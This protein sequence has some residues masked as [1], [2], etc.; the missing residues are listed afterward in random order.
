MSIDISYYIYS[1]PFMVLLYL[2]FTFLSIRIWCLWKDIDLSK[3]DIKLFFNDSFFTRN[4]IYVYCFIIFFLMHGFF[5]GTVV[6]DMYFKT[7]EVLTLSGLVLFT[8]DWYSV[9]GKCSTRRSQPQELID[10]SLF[11]KD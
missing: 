8:Y 1:K 11:K 3:P 10:I 4:C 2:I 5:S 7:L 6:P 9:L